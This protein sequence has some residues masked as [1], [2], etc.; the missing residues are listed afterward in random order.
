MKNNK[1]LSVILCGLFVISLAGCGNRTE[2]IEDIPESGTTTADVTS[3]E[4][5]SDDITAVIESRT[6]ES[7]IIQEQIPIEKETSPKQEPIKLSEKATDPTKASEKPQPTK[8]SILD[9]TQCNHVW[10][11][12]YYVNNKG[13]KCHDCIKC[14][15]VA[16]DAQYKYNPKDWMGNQ[17]E[18]MELLG[19]I[20]E[21]RKE[22]GLHEFKYKTEW[23]AGADQRALD[24]T[25]SFSHTRPDGRPAHTAYTDLGYDVW[26]FAECCHS[27]SRTA[28]EVFESFKS[29]P[30][31]W[32]ILMCTYDI[33]YVAIARCDGYW[34]INLL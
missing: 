10:G 8:P 34:V 19:Y 6:E 24:L 29:S 27:G 26:G 17:A 28:R 32:E 15:Y 31:H 16:E 33:Y 20:N 4:N 25:K 13:N 1:I 23:Q 18:Y 12:W 11:K 5:T 30:A 21:T 9:S 3:T 2:P 7:S 22:K 14:G